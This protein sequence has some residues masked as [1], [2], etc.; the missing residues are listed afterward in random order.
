MADVGMTVE[1]AVQ[2]R[3]REFHRDLDVMCEMA[4]Q[5]GN[6]G[7]KVVWGEGLSYE[8][9]VDPDVPYGHIHEV[10]P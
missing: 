9:S 8:M 7:V 5:Q 4:V 2:Q 6:C 3:V 1:E 10:K